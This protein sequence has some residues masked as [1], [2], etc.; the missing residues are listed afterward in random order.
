[1]RCYIAGP[2][3]GKRHFNFPA[4]FEAEEIVMGLDMIP[5]NPAR[6]DVEE[7]FDGRLL[8]GIDWNKIP[9]GWP[10]VYDFIRRDIALLLDCEAIYLLKGWEG[11]KGARAEY[12]VAVWAGHRIVFQGHEPQGCDW[13]DQSFIVSSAGECYNVNSPR[14]D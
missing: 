3:R 10:D 5:I 13:T 4:F 14:I 11:S 1:M 9:E 7:G 8:S 6:R 2:M 12:A